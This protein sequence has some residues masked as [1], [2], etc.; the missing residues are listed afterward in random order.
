VPFADCSVLTEADELLAGRA[1]YFSVHPLDIGNPP[2]WFLNPFQ[3]KLHPRPVQHWSRIADFSA[4]VGDIKVVWEMSR[5]AWAPILARAW[6]ISGDARYLSAL[7]L[8][9]QDWW[10]CN[11]PNTGP[12]WMCGQETSIRL[13]NA[14]LALRLVGLEKSAEIGLVVF[15]EAHC[16]RVDLT[17]SYA[18]AQDNNHATSEAAGLFVGGTWLAKR[19]EGDAKY[20]G[21]RWAEKGRKLLNGRVRRLVLPDGSFSQHS[22]TY[23]RM[24]LDTLSV[25]EAWRRYMGEA[26][27][28]ED[29]YTRAIAATRWL[30]A[31]ID[32]AS[33]DGPNLGANDG[34]HPYRLDASAYR[35]F[36]PC[37]QLASLLFVS[38]AVLKS[39]P[40]DESAAW[41]GV[42]TEGPVQP[43]L[44]DLSSALF[45]DGGYVVLRND[46][47]ARVLLRAP[48]ARFRP[49]H[50]DAL[51]VDL[52]W[53][54]KNI[55]RDGGTYAYA[56]G[57]AVA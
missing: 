51:H 13:I 38:G 5:F 57:G 2:N 8:W 39:G 40:W 50:A 47:G 41:L 54:G 33:G 43:W 20:R 16:R 10:R 24:M 9:M 11:P 25:A 37:L 55:L 12:N 42:P 49:S 14:L 32:P 3:K 36:R 19:G 4:E 30:G 52:W 1:N 53:K 28:A 26:P 21:Q 34:A 15:V 23:H 45:P 6:R 18:V 7:Q 31:M 56:D 17:T 29:F 22:L 48:T 46:D 27:F 44:S 35:D